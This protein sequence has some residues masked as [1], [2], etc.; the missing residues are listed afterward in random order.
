ME[1]F[2]ALAIIGLIAV[3]IVDASQ[4]RRLFLAEQ[5]EHIS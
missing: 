2:L 1:I 3:V 5:R 4:K